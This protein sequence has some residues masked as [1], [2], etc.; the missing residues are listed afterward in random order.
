MPSLVCFMAPGLPS[1]LKHSARGHLKLSENLLEM[2]ILRP[3]P[4]PTKS[5]NPGMEPED[6]YFMPGVAFRQF[7]CTLK[8]GSPGIGHWNFLPCKWF[9]YISSCN[10]APCT[11]GPKKCHPLSILQFFL[12]QNYDQ[13]ISL[14]K[15]FQSIPSVLNNAVLNPGS[16][17]CAI[18]SAW[19]TPL[20]SSHP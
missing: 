8:F 5:E 20:P 19:G 13:V 2:Y 18:P 1:C 11:P 3:R 17:S 16:C 12:E 7:W 6:L 4:M 15:L 9:P 10:V 14:L